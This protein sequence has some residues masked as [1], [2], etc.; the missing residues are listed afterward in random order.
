[1]VEGREGMEMWTPSLKPFVRK[2]ILE[3]EDFIDDHQKST[4]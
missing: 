2:L 1:M 4:P 3:V